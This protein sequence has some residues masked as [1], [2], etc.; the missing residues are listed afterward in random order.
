MTIDLTKERVE[1]EEERQESCHLTTRGTGRRTARNV[2][3]RRERPSRRVRA[4]SP[5]L[6]VQTLPTYSGESTQHGPGAHLALCNLG[7]NRRCGHT[8]ATASAQ[9]AERLLASTSILATRKVDR[10][11]IRGWS[12]RLSARLLLLR[13]R[14]TGSVAARGGERECARLRLV[15]KL[16]SSSGQARH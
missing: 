1:Q 10:F 14:R 13:S 16:G 3:L 12:T 4:G 15:S 9:L 5:Q 6:K 2:M 8:R 11:D 7:N